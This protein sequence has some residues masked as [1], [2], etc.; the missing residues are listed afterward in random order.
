MISVIIPTCNEE[1]FLPAC[2][3][4]ILKERCDLEI[5]VVDG[6]SKDHTLK[7]ARLYTDKIIALEEANLAVQLNTGAA[8]ADGDILL[9]LHADSRLTKGCL[10]RIKKISPY[11]IGGAFTMQLDGKRFYYRVL[12]MG[13]NLYCR[14]AGTYF[15]DRGIFVRS[16][17]FQ[18]L[19]GFASLPI[20]ADVDF[21]RRMQNLGKCAFLKGPVISSSRKF[22]RE[23]PLRT[24]CLI[25]YAMLAFKLGTDLKTIKKKYYRLP[26]E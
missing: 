7:V 9:F 25:V 17:V 20:M 13:G 22:D 18:E 26:L 12:S 6:A 15:G 23:G 21:S 19:G 3:E 10:D 5:I 1:D 4:S 16:S 8:K 11:A 24:L 14:L 2:L